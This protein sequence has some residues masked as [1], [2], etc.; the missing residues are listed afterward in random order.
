MCVISST[1]RAPATAS[2]IGVPEAHQAEGAQADQLPAEIEEEE[3]GAVDQSD[4]AGDE[5]QHRGVEAGGG[6]V[7]GHVADGV[8]EHECAQAGPH[9]SK[10]D[11]ER[12]HVEDQGQRTIPVEHV[13][14]DCL[15]CLDP[16]HQPGHGSTAGK[17]VRKA[18]IPFVRAEKSRATRIWS[19][20]PSS[21]EHGAIRIRVLRSYLQC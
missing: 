3:V 21:S 5:D 16:A 17:Q 2:R 8:E 4:E 14:I 10:K 11:A 12:V 6:L 20:A 13:Q 18:R 15:A 9:Q 1:L 7:V 19:A